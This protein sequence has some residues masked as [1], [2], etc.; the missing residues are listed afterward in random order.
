MA[1]ALNKLWTTEDYWAIWLGLGIVLLALAAYWS[2]GSI[3]GWAVSPGSWSTVSALG[4]D[5]ARHWGG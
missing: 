4:A 1:R 5:L 3:R 2:G